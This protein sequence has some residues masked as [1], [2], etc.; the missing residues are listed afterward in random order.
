MAQWSS[1]GFMP[2]LTLS[3]SVPSA[4]RCSAEVGMKGLLDSE[5]MSVAAKSA[6]TISATAIAA[7]ERSSVTRRRRQ[8][9]AP[10]KSAM[11]QVHSRSE[12]WRPAHT[13]AT[14]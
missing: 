11:S 10:V 8:A 1:S 5:K 3:T 13:P 14:W 7:L 12:P 4:L 2:A 6:T 9:T